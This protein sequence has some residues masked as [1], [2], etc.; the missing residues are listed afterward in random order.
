MTEDLTKR[1]LHQLKSEN[2]RMNYWVNAL[3]C[4]G[5]DLGEPHSVLAMASEMAANQLINR[6]EANSGEIRKPLDIM[7]WY[8]DLLEKEGLLE[9]ANVSFSRLPA[10]RIRMVVGPNCP[11]AITCQLRAKKRAICIRVLTFVGIIRECLGQEFDYTIIETNPAVKCACELFPTSKPRAQLFTKSQVLRLLRIFTEQM[12]RLQ[13][14]SVEKTGR[15]FARGLTGDLQDCLEQFAAGGL[16]KIEL[17]KLDEENQEVYFKG[18]ELLQGTEASSLQAMDEFTRGFLA[19][20]VSRLC[21][22]EVNCEETDC[23]AKG[24]SACR[25]VV[26]PAHLNN[27]IDFKQLKT[28]SIRIGYI[29]SM[30]HLTLPVAQELLFCKN[31]R[32][33]VELTP[34]IYWREL[35]QAVVEGQVDAGFMMLPAVLNYRQQG[36]LLKLVC[37]GHRNGGCLVVEPNFTDRQVLLRENQSPLLIAIPSKL[38][39]EGLLLHKWMKNSGL[40]YRTVSV[41]SPNMIL[42]LENEEIDGFFC[43]EPFI[44]QVERAGVGRILVSSREIW[45][46]HLCCAM[47]VNQGFYNRHP[48]IVRELRNELITAGSIIENDRLWAASIAAKYFNVAEDIARN[49]LLEDKQRIIYTNL[50]PNLSELNEVQ[51]ALLE[52]G[53]LREK[54]ALNDLLI[55]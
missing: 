10:G 4:I 5:D 49:C 7:R 39:T 16:G 27:P 6:L 31:P 40:T 53:Q 41:P 54:I 11:Y 30:D 21:Q 55:K 42:N 38:G 35:N 50:K 33:K 29:P 46:E 20:L 14:G 44:S 1:L 13:E 51:E 36:V 26:S 28:V 8:R 23:V 32:L 22:A 3:G 2:A 34:Y 17:E 19:G 43:S 12:E 37:F 18:N 24:D 15:R 9:E 25:F 45:P 47:V 52:M 48:D